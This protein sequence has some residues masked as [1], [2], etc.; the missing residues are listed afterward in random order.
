VEVLALDVALRVAVGRGRAGDR[1]LYAE[2]IA[3]S[4]RMARPLPIAN[5]CSRLRITNAGPNAATPVAIFT[6]AL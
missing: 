6:L 2:E 1:W 4:Q 3:A 5:G